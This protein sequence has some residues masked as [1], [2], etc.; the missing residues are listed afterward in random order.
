MEFEPTTTEFHSDAL[1]DWAIRPQVQLALR[2]NFRGVTKLVIFCG[3]YK[4]MT[5]KWLT[6]TTNSIIR[7]SSF[8]FSI[9]PYTFWLKSSPHHTHPITP[10]PT[11]HW[12]PSTYVPF[13]TWLLYLFNGVKTL[14]RSTIKWHFWIGRYLEKHSQFSENSTLLKW[15]FLKTR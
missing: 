2:A 8:L 4:Y 15:D 1:I 11:I 7:G 6:I 12:W 9:N 5:F 13:L 10:L 3:R 14:I